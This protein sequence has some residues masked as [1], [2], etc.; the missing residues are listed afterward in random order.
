MK[1]NRGAL[2][3]SHGAK[4]IAQIPQYFSI[5]QMC[6]SHSQNYLENPP[7]KEV[8]YVFD[9]KRVCVALGR[10]LENLKPTEVFKVKEIL[11]NTKPTI[12]YTVY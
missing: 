9:N 4:T 2:V 11:K 3:L 6:T 7:P 12:L 10:P 8:C 1:A 5:E